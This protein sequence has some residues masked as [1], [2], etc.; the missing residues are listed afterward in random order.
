VARQQYPSAL[1]TAWSSRL[2]N[3]LADLNRRIFGLKG[4]D[5]DAVQAIDAPGSGAP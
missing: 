3:A 1:D 4:G 5:V 2:D